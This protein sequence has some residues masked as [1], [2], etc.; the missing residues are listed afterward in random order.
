MARAAHNFWFFCAGCLIIAHADNAMGQNLL[1]ERTSTVY[2]E[3][4]RTV[5]FDS[6]GDPLPP[7]ARFQFGTERFVSRRPVLDLALSPDGKT[8]LTK[9]A[10][11]IN[12]WETASGKIRWS[13]EVESQWS[14]A[15]GLRAFAFTGDG[16]RFFSQSEPEKLL[17]WNVFTGKAVTIPVKNGLP[18]LPENRPVNSFPGATLAIDVSRDG[19][20]IAAAGGHGI[21]VYDASG[22][23]LFDIPNKPNLAMEPADW[24][25]DQMLMGGHYSLAVFSPDGKT[26]AVVT[27]DLPQRVRLFSA[28]TGEL[29][30]AAELESRLVRMAFSPDG[31]SIGT[32]ERNSAVSQFSTASGKLEWQYQSESAVGWQAIFPQEDFLSSAITY[33][34]DGKFVAAAVPDGGVD[35][36]CLLHASTGMIQSELSGHTQQPWGL[37]F[38]ADSTRLY[39]AG[40][41]RVIRQWDVLKSTELPLEKGFHGS[42][43]VATTSSGNRIAFS[44]SS[45]NIHLSE[46]ANVTLDGK[47]ERIIKT[48][49]VGISALALSRDGRLVA[50]GCS[51]ND[52]S[53]VRVW[54]TT[55]GAALQRWQWGEKG[56]GA[57]KIG[58]LE[59][60]L[61]GIKL[62]ATATEKGKAYLL[63]VRDGKQIAEL[64]HEAICGLSF[65]R[66]GNQLVTAGANERLCFW[67]S[68]S[69]KL[70]SKIEMIGGDLQNVRCSPVDDLIVTAHFPNVLRVWN[71]KDMTLRKRAPQSGEANF[72]ALAFSSDGN[73][74]ATGTSGIVNILNART[75][76]R[77]WQAGSHNGRVLTLGFSEQDRVLVSGGNDGM[78]YGWELMPQ[79]DSD[80]PDYDRIWLALCNGDDEEIKVLKW[81]L[82]QAG[83]AAV[84][85]VAR[86]LKPVTR[87]VNLRA[88]SKGLNRQ[89]AET[90]VRLA[91]QL[92]EKNPALEIDV[93]LKNLVDFLAILRNPRSIA[94]LEQLAASHASKDVRREAMFALETIR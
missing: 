52:E 78:V 91:I 87:I 67:D 81:E 15:Y 66:T 5:R 18:L 82:V 79:D 80:G 17:K 29:Q 45:G 70:I 22:N 89:T 21:V 56:Q 94:L 53:I 86:R 25:K 27:S 75:A 9:D 30:C 76:E 46:T 88:I 61:D 24:H 71:S 20:R 77:I 73:W 8:L 32:T 47:G 31:N 1:D 62:A 41:D 16:E 92:C 84:D 69:G 23:N 6:L 42:G 51:A 43:I 12:C 57:P 2:Q 63:D 90:R 40:L 59:F 13:A 58:M 11:N 65:D 49:N 64:D 50:S 83:D 93:R 48:P 3:R 33:S 10:E 19:S 28:S 55:T 7:R 44:D 26:M 54:D 85:E 4:P 72:E 38:T 37:A 74:L 35:S 14:P 68:A 60:S 36:I 34:P 39:S